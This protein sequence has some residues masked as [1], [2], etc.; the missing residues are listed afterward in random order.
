M[1]RTATAA[2]TSFAT[3]N[4]I[5][6]ETREQITNLLN[7]RLADTIDLQ[8]QTKQAHWNVKG[9]SF[10]ALHKLFDE[11]HDAV[12]EYVD[13]IAE[14]I[15]ALGGVAQ[16]TLNDVAEQTELEPYPTTIANGE[17][18][19]KAL[20]AALAQFGARSRFTIDELDEL[21]DQVSVDILTEITRGTDQW[22]WF[23]EAHHQAPR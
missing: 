10:I 2:P 9:P 20:S 5:S 15:T 21:G 6:A 13:L 18:H 8:L 23:V 11:I 14:R 1:N 17:D 19:V 22:L 7:R 3:K 4:S 16:G 12:R